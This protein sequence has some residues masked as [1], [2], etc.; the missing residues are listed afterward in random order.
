MGKEKITT[1]GRAARAAFPHTV[2]VMA[3]YV[4]I[5]I[6]FGLMLR[7]AG[8]GALWAA[9]MSLL[10]YTGAGQ[11]MAVPLLAAS[12]PLGRVALLTAVI[13]LRHLVYGLSMLDKFKDL[14]WKR[15]LYLIFAL[16]DETYALLA[17]VQPPEGVDT[18]RFYTAIA[19]LDQC[20]WVV[21]SVVGSLFGSLLTADLT[22]V[23]F[24]MTALFLAILTEQW[25]ERQNRLPALL[26]LAVTAV[27]LALAGTERMLVPALAAV[28]ALLLAMRGPI[29]APA[30][31]RKGG[32]ADGT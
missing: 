15:K 12:A 24:A 21:G 23:D 5:G 8:Y 27:S 16:S 28:V 19:A 11:I 18:D 2:P 30:Q 6:A 1:W 31:A 26:G 7:S 20:Y 4:C 9:C 32:G 13:D 25:R 14:P 10:V 3:G 29:E 17:G 22:G